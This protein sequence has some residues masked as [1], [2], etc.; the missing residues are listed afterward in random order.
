MP[1]CHMP[2]PL[3]ARCAVACTQ[4]R[5]FLLRGEA[6]KREASTRMQ[7]GKVAR[8]EAHTG[9]TKPTA[10][11]LSELE[12]AGVSLP[13][14]A[15]MLALSQVFQS[16]LEKARAKLG[17][18]PSTNWTHLFND[19]DMDGSGFITYD[20]LKR[21]VR[22]SLGLK[23]WDMP[24]RQLAALWCALDSDCSNAIQLDEMIGFLGGRV[25]GFL[26]RGSRGGGVSLPALSHVATQRSAEEAR[27]VAKAAKLAEERVEWLAHMEKVWAPP[28][29][30][31]PCIPLTLLLS[32]SSHICIHHTLLWA[33]WTHT[34]SRS[35]RISTAPSALCTL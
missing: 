19:L 1:D 17:K 4:M 25:K 22:S 15:E 16:T 26:K 34:V 9:Y 18:G 6:A 13:G 27:A 35:A 2:L 8:A 11:M 24:E 5:R 3:P 28:H 7:F 14:E 29:L 12:A 31:L 10:E 23:P 30:R 20:E 21:M 33:R 32:P